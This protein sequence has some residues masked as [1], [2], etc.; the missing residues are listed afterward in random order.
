MRHVA[1]TRS[2]VVLG[3]VLAGAC[4]LFARLVSRPA[5]TAVPRSAGEA[6]FEQRCAGCHVPA[7]VD[8]SLRPPAERAAA[9][10]A[11]SAELRRFLRGH[12]HSSPDEDEALV[13][14]LSARAQGG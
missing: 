4:L 8:A 6:L 14:F 7:D 12:G 2:V 3:L 10:A 5:G 13:E 11:A 9:S 1:V